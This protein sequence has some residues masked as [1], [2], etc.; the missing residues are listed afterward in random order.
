MKCLCLIFSL[1]CHWITSLVPQALSVQTQLRQLP[2]DAGSCEVMTQ[3]PQPDQVPVP[4]MQLG[5]S[6]GNPGSC[7]AHTEEAR[8]ATMAKDSVWNSP[9]ICWYSWTHFSIWL[10]HSRSQPCCTIKCATFRTRK[11]YDNDVWQCLHVS[12]ALLAKWAVI[13]CFPGQ[14]QFKCQ[15]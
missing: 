15:R 1:F 14:F 2:W 5:K 8:R 6:R 13:S 11:Q 10:L 4:Q 12:T 9:V 7:G 3:A